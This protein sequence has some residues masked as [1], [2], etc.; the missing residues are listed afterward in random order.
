M[1]E[2]KPSPTACIICSINCG[3]RVT[4]EGREITAVHGDREHPTSKGYLCEKAQSLNVYQNG[5]DR[6]SSPLRR[7]ADGTFEAVDWDTAISEIAARLNQVKA[8]H[9]GDKIFYYG[10]GAQGNHLG[11]GY[12]RA[13]RAALG[14]THTSNALAQEKTGEFWVDGQL[15]GRPRCHTT[16][17][18][19]N[20]EVAVLVG[21]NPWH[22]HGFPRARVVLKQIAKDPNRTL[23]VI[24]PRKTETAELADIHLQVR[25]GGDAFLLSAMVA[26]LLRE[27]GIK[28]EWL[29]AH[30]VGLDELKS[31]FERV[32]V[33]AYCK[34]AGVQEA[35]VRA[36][37]KRIAEAASVSV[38]EDLGI[39]QAPHS[40]LCSWL[41]K[42]LYLLTGHFGKKGGMNIHS[43]FASL[44]GGGKGGRNATTPVHG[45]RLIGGLTPCNVIADEILTD[46]PNRFR[47]M[48]VESANPAHSLADSKRFVEALRALDFVLVIDVAMSETARHADYVLPA[49][50]QFEKWEA[51]FFNLEFPRNAIHL[52][53]P[54]FEPLPGTLPEVEIHARLVK[55][56]GGLDGLD[57]SMFH[58]AAGQGFEAF[59]MTFAMAAASNSQIMDMAPIILYETMGP[60]L[61]QHPPKGANSFSVDSLR[62]TAGMW[63]VCHQ[64]A[65][66]YPDSVRRAGIG[67][68]AQ[69]LGLGNA[70]FQ[71]LL[72][73]PSGVVFSDDPYQETFARLDTPDK[74]IRLVVEPLVSEFVSLASEVEARSGGTNPVH[75]AYPFILAAGERRSTTANTLFRDPSWREN[76]GTL[77]MSQEDAARLGL[78]SGDAAKITTK[79]GSAVAFVELTDTLMP[80]HVTLPNGHGLGSADAAHS[81]REGVAPN[82][83]TSADDRDPIAGTPWHK[84]VRARIERAI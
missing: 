6:L 3:V 50:S 8:A 48:I 60:L 67:V 11:G 5:R 57:L 37:V 26:L 24:D 55:A 47:A 58:N 40:T 72:D 68:D 46:H 62:Q 29:S 82:D 4:T 38:L 59:A 54:L 22:S 27:G 49:A 76:S 17:D 39:Q 23:I 32:D 28:A 75:D 81:Q 12:G 16:P 2:N 10:G 1:N 21:K 31:L 83:L 79:R 66:A 19:H 74:M 56:L 25:P 20:A 77:R 15:F 36:A 43:R 30:A 9:G 18:F 14:S 69:G 35:D 78:H 34:A 52:R 70:L 84:H 73:N 33:A 61:A 51:T 71:A 41:E 45:H 80:G 44:G 7:K 53:R 64:V 65:M 42:L 63:G 13:L